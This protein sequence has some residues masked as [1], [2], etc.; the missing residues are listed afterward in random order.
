MLRMFGH[1]NVLPSTSGLALEGTSHCL[2]LAMA[3]NCGPFGSSEK[4]SL[5]YSRKGE[6][7]RGQP[8]QPFLSEVLN[9][10]DATGQQSLELMEIIDAFHP[11]GNNHLSTCLLPNMPDTVHLLRVTFTMIRNPSAFR[12]LLL[13]GSSKLWLGL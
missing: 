6:V 2:S 3:E 7:W 12:L 4:G 11:Q 5:C 10:R 1:L 13:K 8:L 9:S